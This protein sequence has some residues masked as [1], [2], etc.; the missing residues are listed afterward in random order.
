MNSTAQIRTMIAATR[1][2]RRIARAEADADARRVDVEQHHEPSS[3]ACMGA[4]HS[5]SAWAR[6]RNV[7]VPSD[8]VA[9][10]S[11][12][13]SRSHPSRSAADCQVSRIPWGRRRDLFR[14]DVGRANGT[15][16]RARAQSCEQ[17]AQPRGF[18]G[19]ARLI[20]EDE[21][22]AEIHVQR[23]RARPEDRYHPLTPSFDPA[24]EVSS[25]PKP[26]H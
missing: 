24:L 20:S 5:P 11:S 2:H 25:S 12:T 21:T 18:G 6:L 3:V 19:P 16:V 23:N 10:A 17:L 1:K 7:P 22:H 9:A 8:A 14:T 4:G 15:P 13:T 26:I